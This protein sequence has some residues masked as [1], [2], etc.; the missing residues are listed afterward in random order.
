MAW[1]QQKKRSDG[2]TSAAVRWRLGG[3]RSGPMQTETFRQPSNAGYGGGSA[4][5]IPVRTTTR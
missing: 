3:A 4:S 5:A 2:G 1:I